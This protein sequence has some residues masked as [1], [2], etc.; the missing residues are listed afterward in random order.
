MDDYDIADLQ[1]LNNKNKEIFRFVLINLA[2]HDLS[3]E[4]MNKLYADINSD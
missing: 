2:H 4:D 1:E 3:I